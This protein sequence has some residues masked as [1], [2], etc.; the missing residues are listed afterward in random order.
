[1]S[2]VRFPSGSLG[3]RYFLHLLISLRFGL[4]LLDHAGVA[5]LADALDLGSSGRPCRFKSCHPHRKDVRLNVFFI[6]LYNIKYDIIVNGKGGNKMKELIDRLKTFNISIIFYETTN[7]I[8]VQLFRYVFVGGIAFV[9]DWGMLVLLH[10][11][12]K[13][14]VYLA[15]AIAFVF[16]LI[17]NF[18]LSKKFVFKEKSEKTNGLGEFVTYGIIGVI[19]LGLTEVIMWLLLKL[20]IIYMMAKVIAAVIVLLWNFIARKIILYR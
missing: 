9:A 12:V 19:G 4:V 3:A 13:I 20:S 5:E 1:M 18:F 10:E 7:N 2:G 14:N 11:A 15:T 6:L 16:G 17:V 8:V